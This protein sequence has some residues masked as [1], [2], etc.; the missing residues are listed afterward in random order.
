MHT[1]IYGSVKGG[2]HSI[3]MKGNGTRRKNVNP[4]NR[5][6]GFVSFFPGALPPLPLPVDQSIGPPQGALPLDPAKA[7]ALGPRGNNLF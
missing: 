3:I 1:D 2:I 6:L 4:I 5:I 7:A